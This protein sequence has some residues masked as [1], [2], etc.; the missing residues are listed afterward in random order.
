[1]LAAVALVVE[2]IVCLCA[3]LWLCLHDPMFS[4]FIINVRIIPTCERQKDTL[5]YMT[6]Q[7]YVYSITLCT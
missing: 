6:A 3:I 1:M 2:T 4:R 5:T 7:L